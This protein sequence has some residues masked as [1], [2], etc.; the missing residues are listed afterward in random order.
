MATQKS[1]PLPFKTRLALLMMKA[2]KPAQFDGISPRQIRKMR[3][4]LPWIWP[5]PWIFGKPAKCHSIRDFTF[6]ARDGAR[7]RARMYIPENRKGLPIV[8]NYHGGGWVIGTLQQC[9]YYCSHLSKRTG[10]I[11]ISVDYRMAPDHP[12]PQA[13]H[14]AYD[15]LCW[16]HDN[17]A[18]F[19]GDPS[20]I[21][22]TGD[23]AGG[24]LAAAACL[25]SRDQDGP[26]I[27]FQALIYPATDVRLEFPSLKEHPH[28]PMLSAASIHWFRDQYISKEEDKRNPY[29]TPA[30]AESHADLPPA[31]IVTADWDPLRDDGRQYADILN[32]AGVP[33]EYVNIEESFHA[34]MT[35]PNHFN[36]AAQALDLIVE[37]VR[38]CF[39]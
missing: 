16:A 10:F 39:Q 23:S 11:V 18:T 17:A 12:F 14:D 36:G 6:E 8:M 2:V 22:V 15:A 24:N 21:A 25:M 5:I 37:R 20:R 30:L 13:I 35:F 33:A 1:Y 29:L 28:A 38:R 4:A 19:G 34:F 27:A 3:K 9:D 26:K 31:L 32:S 7:V